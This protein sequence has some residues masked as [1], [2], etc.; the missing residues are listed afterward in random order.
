MNTLITSLHWDDNPPQIMEKQKK[1]FNKFGYEIIQT[2]ANVRHPDY[3]DWV[4]NN[5]NYDRYLFVD[6]DCIPLSADVVEEAFNKIANSDRL[7]GCAQASNHL[8]PEA[9]SNIYAAAFFL[10]M[11]QDLYS[12]LGRPSFS[13]THRSD[14]A[15]ELTWSARA[16]GLPVEL[17][18]P[19][20][21]I[22]EKIWNLG[23]WGKYG[24]GSFYSE[25]ES[26]V[27]K[28]FHLFQIRVSVE[29]NTLGIFLDQC[30]Q[31]INK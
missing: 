23:S 27:E 31:I 1:V 16:I 30:D 17:W 9:N 6:S 13:E 14:V 15:A 29:R 11:T 5:T 8:S 3:M 19:T 2:R 4:M 10:P 20:R 22:R 12:K 28:V 24:E 21:C 18:Y 25:E 26:D 7:F